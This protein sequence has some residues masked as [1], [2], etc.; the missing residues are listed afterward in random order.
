[1]YEY[2]LPAI[3]TVVGEEVSTLV[4][5]DAL[6]PNVTEV[7][8]TESTVRK[9]TS[10]TFDMHVETDSVLFLGED[11]KT[12]GV[13]FTVNGNGKGLVRGWNRTDSEIVVHRDCPPT[14]KYRL[15]MPWYADVPVDYVEIHFRPYERTDREQVG[16]DGY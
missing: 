9:K 8:V 5:A 2:E 11:H 1:M 7:R 10:L 16:Q 13:V 15:V 3:G 4:N 6:P 12:I 14:S